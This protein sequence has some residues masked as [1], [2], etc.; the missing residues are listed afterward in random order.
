MPNGRSGG[1]LIPTTDLKR[2]VEALPGATVIG[3]VLVHAPPIRPAIASEVIPFIDACS[4][5]RVG[6][7]EQDHKAYVVHLL[8]EPKP[9]CLVV[10]SKSPLF[11]ALQ[12]SHTQWLAD[13]PGWTGWM[14]F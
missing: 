2:L 5:D 3:A 1:F 10:D 13:H 8:D 6:V 11:S 14:A 7:E 12:R 9:I 4:H